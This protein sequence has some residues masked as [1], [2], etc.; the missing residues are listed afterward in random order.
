MNAEAGRAAVAQT[1]APSPR[2]SAGPVELHDGRR[3]SWPVRPFE[4]AC[5][6][7]HRLPA[8]VDPRCRANRL[9]PTFFRLHDGKAII[10]GPRIFSPNRA[11]RQKRRATQAGRRVCTPSSSAPANLAGA[12]TATPDADRRIGVRFAAQRS[13]SATIFATPRMRCT[14][15]ANLSVDRTTAA[16]ED[17]L[18]PNIGQCRAP[19]STAPNAGRFESRSGQPLRCVTAMPAR[20]PVTNF[21]RWR[22]PCSALTPGPQPTDG[23]PQRW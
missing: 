7:S 16:A 20:R 2:W 5:L 23:R 6:T 12:K 15:Y 8:D 22:P 3:Q 10:P 18:A 9:T 17:P 13:P 14:A 1:T 11:D 4:N 19:E 21:D